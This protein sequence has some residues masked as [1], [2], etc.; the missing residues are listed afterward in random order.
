MGCSRTPSPTE[1]R[2]GYQLSRRLACLLV[3][4]LKRLESTPLCRLAADSTANA[5]SGTQGTE[6]LRA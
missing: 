6:D 5:S 4:H 1:T 2:L 3:G